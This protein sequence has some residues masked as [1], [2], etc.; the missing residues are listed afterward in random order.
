MG[1][2]TQEFFDWVESIGKLDL[3]EA[4]LDF[5]ND[6]TDMDRRAKAINTLIELDND[7]IKYTESK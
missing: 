3:Y 7:F 4:S 6:F 2:R 5:Q 1:N